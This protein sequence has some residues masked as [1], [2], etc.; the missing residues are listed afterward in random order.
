M[1]K[2]LYVETFNPNYIP[3]KKSILDEDIEFNMFFMQ[4]CEQGGKFLPNCKEK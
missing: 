3:G 4:H 2:N 1:A